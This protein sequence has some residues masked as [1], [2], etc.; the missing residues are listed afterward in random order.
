MSSQNQHRDLRIF[1]LPLEGVEQT[2][3]LY[4]LFTHVQ[5]A[6]II[7]YQP[8]QKIPFSDRH[9][10][11][12]V[13]YQNQLLPVIN[14]SD[15]CAPTIAPTQ[16]RYKQLMVIRTGACD[17]TTGEPLKVAIM[18][19]TAIRTLKLTSQALTDSFLQQ[20]PPHWLQASKELRGFFKWQDTNVALL[21]FDH[22]AAG[23]TTS[24]RLGNDDR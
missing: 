22:L 6:E 12:I 4:F 9:L 19:N 18:A 14:V 10:L 3:T 23:N 16:N 5:V 8:I 1:L 13:P 17:P 2:D 15:L 24:S 7:G 20:D 21:N 11:G